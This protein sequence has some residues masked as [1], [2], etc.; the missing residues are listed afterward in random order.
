MHIDMKKIGEGSYADVYKYKDEFYDRWFVVKRAKKNLN[1]KERMRFKREYEIMKNFSSPYILEV[2]KYKDDKNEYIMECM[3]C[4][5]RSYISH[6]NS[7]LTIAERKNIAVQVLKAFD[8]IHSKKCLHRDIS[9]NNILIKEYEDVLV[10]KISDFGLVKIPESEL[11]TMGTEFK[12]CFNDPALIVDGFGTYD[13]LHETYALTRVIY[14][15]MTG[16]TN[17]EKNTNSKLKIFLEKGLNP[18]RTQRYKSVHEMKQVLQKT[19]Q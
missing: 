13:I 1:E 16:K 7:K 4:T 12:G 8:Y 17:V 19:L 2:Y 11:T 3:D 18:D 6:N 15:I 10:V 9:P 14:Y 5:L